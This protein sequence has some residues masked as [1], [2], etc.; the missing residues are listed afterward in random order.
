MKSIVL[1]FVILLIML[2]SMT[3][4]LIS[5]AP[6]SKVVSVYTAKRISNT[7]NMI[8]DASSSETSVVSI[9]QDKIQKALEAESVKVTGK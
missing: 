8:S 9:C 3:R 4:A 7:R 2:S 1:A 6:C 5:R